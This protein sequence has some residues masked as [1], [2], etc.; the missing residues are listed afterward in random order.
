[1]SCLA[2][3]AAIGIPGTALAAPG[4]HT[5]GQK[6]AARE[7]AT[8]AQLALHGVAFSAPTGALTL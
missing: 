6:H 8:V 2:A 5:A 4:P 7:S 3:A 1:M